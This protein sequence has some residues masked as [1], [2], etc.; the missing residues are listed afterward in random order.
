MKR[1]IKVGDKLRVNDTQG[2]DAL[3]E[4]AVGEIVTCT[5]LCS[6][7]NSTG[8]RGVYITPANREQI[9][10][11]F[12]ARRFD[13]VDDSPMS[14]EQQ[15][16][17]AKALVGKRVKDKDGSTDTIQRVGIEIDD[18]PTTSLLVNHETKKNGFCVYV[19]GELYTVP[20]NTIVEVLPNTIEVRL[21][22]TYKATVSK[23]SIEVGCQ[24]FPID[25]LDKLVEARNALAK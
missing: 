23:D 17:A 11:W 5:E 13:H 12:Y 19:V 10:G 2:I 22:E 16:V 25:I 3:H 7:N 4:V 18:N 20:F 9:V 14:L 24:T 6:H 1:E 21:N 8:T 15:L